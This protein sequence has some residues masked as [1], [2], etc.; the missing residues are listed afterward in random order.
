MP[1]HAS[2][3]REC[4]HNLIYW[5]QGGWLAAGPSASGHVRVRG[6]GAE[7]DGGLAGH[8][9]KNAPSLG[10]YL[11]HGDRGFAPIVDH[12]P[13]DAARAVR[14]R[15]MTGVRLREGLDPA[16]LLRASD[17]AV[18]GSG[19]RLER[20]ARGLR[21]D[22][23]LRL[24]PERWQVHGRGWLLADWIARRLMACV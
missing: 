5:R 18:P 7:D 4:L 14:E 12:E 23:L 1:R 6:G 22:G 9:W 16:G 13:P 21:D 2:A 17:Q 20:E 15:I 19:A 3:R 11:A 24:A 10:T 8:R